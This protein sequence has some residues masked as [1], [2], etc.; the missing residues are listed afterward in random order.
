M[1][2]LTCLLS[3]RILKSKIFL[4]L[5][6]YQLKILVYY[7]TCFCHSA[8]SLRLCILKSRIFLKST[9]IPSNKAIGNIKF[10]KILEYLKSPK[11]ELKLLRHNLQFLSFQSRLGL[12]ALLDVNTCSPI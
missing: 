2:C 7:L 6:I 12:C 9:K 1:N 3:F 11:K 10:F 8:L 5:E 4:K